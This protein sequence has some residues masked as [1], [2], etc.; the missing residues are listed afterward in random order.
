MDPISSWSTST[1]NARIKDLRTS[2]G[3]DSSDSLYVPRRRSGEDPYRLSQSVRCDWTRFLQ[4]VER[5]LPQAP[6]A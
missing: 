4:L 1:L 6:R 5:V 2:L 3:S